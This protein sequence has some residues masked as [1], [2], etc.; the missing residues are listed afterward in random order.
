[1]QTRG[2]DPWSVQT[3]GENLIAL[4]IV[5]NE[6]RR[7][8]YRGPAMRITAAMNVI[9]CAVKAAPRE[10]WRVSLQFALKIEINDELQA[11]TIEKRKGEVLKA[12]H[13]SPNSMTWLEGEWRDAFGH[14]AID[15]VRRDRSRCEDGIDPLFQSLL[16][17]SLRD[18]IEEL[19]R[20][21]EQLEGLH[22]RGA[23]LTDADRDILRQIRERFPVAFDHFGPAMGDE[24]AF[25]LIV[26]RVL[27]TYYELERR[28]G[29]R[30][31]PISVVA[32]FFHDGRVSAPARSYIPHGQEDADATSEV[33][34]ASLLLLARGFETAQAQGWVILQG[35]ARAEM[36]M[37]VD[38]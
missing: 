23:Q 24:I 20:K 26:T 14:L 32:N 30:Y 38:F 22:R 2:L 4:P 15:L 9:E 31:F 10:V 3:H 29:S 7:L 13:R 35:D 17:E 34:A 11:L 21:F 5:A 25:A 1:M 6:V 27:D 36:Q 28:G 19:A 33:W 16:N 8:R 18:V 12:L 37:N